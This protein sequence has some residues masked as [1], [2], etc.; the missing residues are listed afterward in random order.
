M[1]G[2]GRHFQV[3]VNGDAQGMTMDWMGTMRKTTRTKEIK[4]FEEF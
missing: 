4:A 2:W 3:V 1:N